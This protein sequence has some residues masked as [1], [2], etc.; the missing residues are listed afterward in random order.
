MSIVS[1]SDHWLYISSTG[2]LAAGRINP[3]TYLDVTGKKQ[4][5]ALEAGSL[6][7]TFCQVPI[8]YRSSSV[9]KM[10]VA[11]ADG[12]C[13]DMAGTKLNTELSQHIF[14]RDG[15]IKQITVNTSAG[16]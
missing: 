5:I 8:V 9:Q 16:M 15:D 6:A 4:E 12:K 13:L 7:Y 11:F 3:F 14:Q 10:Q 1:D 2:G